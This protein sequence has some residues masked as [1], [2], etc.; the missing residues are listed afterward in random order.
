M[1][2]KM[3]M[4]LTH[5]T[6]LLFS[7]LVIIVFV[8]FII[9]LDTEKEM[10][11][12]HGWVLHS[13]EVI[14][15]SEKFLGYMRDAETGQRG[16][17]LTLNDNYLEPYHG[18][19]INAQTQIS[20]IRK[21]TVDHSEQ[22]TQL[23]HIQD[24]MQKKLVELEETV[25]LAQQGKS[26]EALAIVNNDSG[27]NIMDDIRERVDVVTS[28]ERKLLS[29]LKIEYQKLKNDLKI[30]FYI[31]A[32]FLLLL[33]ILFYFYMQKTISFPIVA[34]AKK[35]TSVKDNIDGEELEL[36]PR[37]D[38]IGTLEGSF[39]AMVRKLKEQ[40]EQKEDLIAQIE[41]AL[42][43]IE[44]LKGIIPICIDCHKIKDDN[45][46]WNRLEAYLEERSDAEFS[47]GM[48]PDCFKI[49]EAKLLSE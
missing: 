20:L 11:A 16:F 42:A 10:D 3:R 7:F 21:L 25:H 8:D 28:V 17:L 47:H 39:D 12:Q 22:Q 45:G 19:V 23:G 6:T 49:K 40:S 9:L 37:G 24:L 32:L 29:Q 36:T 14:E 13:H 5:K 35:M 46:D 1:L 43:E 44:T 18:G 41:I 38:E 34:L 31:E 33:I 4:N 2:F 27:K 30:L 15:A 48:C 26:E